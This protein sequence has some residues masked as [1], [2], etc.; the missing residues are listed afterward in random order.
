MIKKNFFIYLYILT[1]IVFFI[2]SCSTNITTNDEILNFDVFKTEEPDKL[3]FVCDGIIN[4]DKL[5][6]LLETISINVFCD[7]YKVNINIKDC[8]ITRVPINKDSTKFSILHFLHLKNKKT[9]AKNFKIFVSYLSN[10]IN[11]DIVI[12]TSTEE[13]LFFPDVY[14]DI[15]GVKFDIYTARLYKNEEVKTVNSSMINLLIADGQEMIIW[16]S[17][18]NKK[19]FQVLSEIQPVEIGDFYRTY[20]FWN[21]KYMFDANIM[22]IPS[23]IEN[24]ENFDFDRRIQ[25]N[26]ENNDMPEELIKPMTPILEPGIYKV[27]LIIPANKTY[28]H[29][30]K[31]YLNNYKS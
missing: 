20:I 9:T 24:N 23:E 25:E 22:K 3:L 15:S 30:F 13:I 19:Y 11:K 12:N 18:I 6:E 7:S 1:F 5:L 4:N 31:F 17:S 28:E 14:E 16:D 26:F 29:S 8:L 27:F 2:T 10:K 21:K